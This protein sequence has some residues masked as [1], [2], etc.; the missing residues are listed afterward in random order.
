MFMIKSSG[1]SGTVENL[2]FNNF[3]GHSN[4]YTLDVDTAWAP[5]TVTAGDG[6]SYSNI[7][8]NTW[9]GTAADGTERGPIKMNCPAA[10]PC[11][12]I[13]IENFNVWTDTS[14]DTVLYGCQN[15]YGSG[16]CLVAGDASD[17]AYTTTQTVAS[18]GDYA[19]TTM[20]NE[21][22]TGYDISASIPIPAMPAS[23][24]PGKAPISAFLAGSADA[25]AATGAAVA[26]DA[27]V[28]ASSPATKTSSTAA[29]TATPK[30]GAG[31]SRGKSN[32]KAQVT[33]AARSNVGSGKRS[34]RLRN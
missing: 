26:T 9:T 25:A 12:D 3:M 2:A 23:F 29:A 18:V 16:G 24:Y 31:G 21:L 6:I 11:T 13:T 14:A 4:A 17:G 19:Y 33:P 27:D 22:A 32:A 30:K 20:A 28:A 15:A 34:A 1:G 10:V 5:M 8:F 7:S